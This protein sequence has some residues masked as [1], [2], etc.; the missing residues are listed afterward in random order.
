MITR[1]GA[2]EVAIDN[3]TGSRPGRLGTNR[4]DLFVQP[5]SGIRRVT[6]GIAIKDVVYVPWTGE[7]RKDVGVAVIL[8]LTTIE[9]CSGVGTFEYL[10][11]SQ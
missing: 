5:V 11:S 9:I 1:T 8:G 6:R 4:K 2:E 7:R 10:G 3:G